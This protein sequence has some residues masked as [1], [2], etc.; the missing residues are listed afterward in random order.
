MNTYPDN[1]PEDLICKCGRHLP[2]RHC[3]ETILAFDLGTKTGWASVSSG[4]ILSGMTDMKKEAKRRGFGCMFRAYQCWLL[5]TFLLH[6]PDI[7]RYEDVKRHMGTRAAHVYGA[8]KAILEIECDKHGVKLEGYGVGTIK[9]S[10]TGNGRA[11]KEEMIDAA[12]KLVS[13]SITDDNEAD[14][15]CIAT[16]K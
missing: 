7:V 6:K 9:K 15:I 8:W 1:Q 10:A 3:E 13:H 14:A 11:S 12:S 16:L 4:S 2:C 5:D